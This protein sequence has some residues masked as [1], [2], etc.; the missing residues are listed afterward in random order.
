[1]TTLLPGVTACRIGTKRLTAN[2]LEA[3]GRTGAPVLFVHGNVSSSLWC[4]VPGAQRQRLR[5]CQVSGNPGT[6]SR[7]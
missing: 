2:V 6:G 1:M 5:L 4:A 3:D 7:V